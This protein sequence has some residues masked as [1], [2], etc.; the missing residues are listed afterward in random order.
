MFDCAGVCGISIESE[1]MRAAFASRYA[2]R[3]S[4]IADADHADRHLLCLDS[5]D[6]IRC[7]RQLLMHAGLLV[8]LQDRLTLSAS[9]MAVDGPGGKSPFQE[10]GKLWPARWL[11]TLRSV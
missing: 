4:D 9:R 11:V 8:L 7:Q 1:Y 6:Q 10:M 2:H 5:D 3:Q